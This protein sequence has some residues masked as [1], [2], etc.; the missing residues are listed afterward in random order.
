VF[1]RPG[2]VR[3]FIRVRSSPGVARGYTHLT[4]LGYGR[5]EK[6]ARIHP[7]VLNKEFNV[8]TTVARQMKF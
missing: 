1:Q 3:L 5:A 8:F 7:L 6:D 2:F 4:P